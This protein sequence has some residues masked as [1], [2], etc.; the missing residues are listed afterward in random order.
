MQDNT[1]YTSLLNTVL[2][3]ISDAWASE[4]QKCKDLPYFVKTV[5]LLQKSYLSEVNIG[6]FFQ[7]MQ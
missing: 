6:E 7:K 2:M 1:N 4:I 3:P 5:L